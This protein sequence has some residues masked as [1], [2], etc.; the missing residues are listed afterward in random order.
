MVCPHLLPKTAT[1]YPETGDFVAVFGEYSSKVAFSAT[2]V[3]RPF[4]AFTQ[5]R[6]KRREQCLAMQFSS[7]VK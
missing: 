7:N 4:N 2:G 6:K 3:D 5:S 1:L